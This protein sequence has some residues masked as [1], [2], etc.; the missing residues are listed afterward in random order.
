V[1]IP[2][3][4]LEKK[5]YI[6]SKN[7]LQFITPS[8]L[9]LNADAVKCGSMKIKKKIDL[10]PNVF[11]A[12]SL[13]CGLFVIF[14]MSMVPEVTR[15]LLTL[16]AGILLLGALADLLDGAIARVVKA[17]STFGGFFDSMSDSV[18][19]GVA[20][21]VIVLKSLPLH[22][23]TDLAYLVTAAAMVYTVCGVLRLVRFNVSGLRALEDTALLEAH[24]KTFT[25]LPIP[26][27]ATALV[28][29]NLFIASDELKALGDIDPTTRSWIL[30]S[31]MLLLGFFM[32][33]RCKFPSFKALQIRI[34]S[35]RQVLLIVVFTVFVVFYGLMQHFSVVFLIAS[36]SYVIIAWILA[37][38]RFILGKQAKTLQDFEPEPE[39]DIEDL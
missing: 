7:L 31:Q 32:V 30:F 9:K 36:W 1:G 23:G 38:V 35:F 5:P 13:C 4:K 24:K 27:A 19:F 10:L 28:S 33:S 12:F 34:S 18:T 22:P 11:T 17:E 3:K 16:T 14:K 37:L 25:G 29:S 6:R 8:L 39:E 2:L 15:E 26:A 20:P 21:A